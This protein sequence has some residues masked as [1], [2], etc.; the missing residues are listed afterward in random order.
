MKHTSSKDARELLKELD[1]GR[2]QAGFHETILAGPMSGDL[3]SSW[4]D[5]L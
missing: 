4:G 3:P 5:R 1:K 2:Y